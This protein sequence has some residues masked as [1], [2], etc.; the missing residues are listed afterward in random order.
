MRAAG[1]AAVETPFF[2]ATALWRFGHNDDLMTV[3]RNSMV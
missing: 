2:A 1:L 3:W